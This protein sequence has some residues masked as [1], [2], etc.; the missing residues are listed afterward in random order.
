MQ[1]QRLPDGGLLVPRAWTDPETGTH[2]YGMV[3]VYP[4]D[5]LYE[6][7]SKGLDP[8]DDTPMP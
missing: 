1:A 4:G 5:P 3:T 6:A 7:W 2:F 8:S